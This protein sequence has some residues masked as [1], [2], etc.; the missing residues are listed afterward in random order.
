MTLHRKNPRL[1]VKNYFGCQTYFI[2]ICCDRRTK[3][4]A[5]SPFALGVVQIL[6]EC[7]TSQAFLLHAYCV[8]PDHIH[9]LAEG[10]HE[11]SDLRELSVF[12]SNVAPLNFESFAA[13]LFGKRATTSTFFARRMPSKTSPRTYGGIPCAKTFAPLRK[14][15]RFPVLKPWIGRTA[16]FSP[17]P[18][19][20]CSGGSLDP[21]FWSFFS[22]SI[23]VH[24][25][26]FCSPSVLLS[27]FYA[28]DARSVPFAS[29]R[30][31][32]CSHREKRGEKAEV[33][34]KGKAKRKEREEKERV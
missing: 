29:A 33:K 17:R 30:R 23:L 19:S 26:F 9:F 6:L 8:M 24:S 1:S 13:N 27:F 2:T 10:T 22:L 25:S 7:A 34:R 15:F 18:G 20:R 4:L 16:L 31:S 12:S 11:G 32:A 14:N 3:Y 21:F 5:S 28:L